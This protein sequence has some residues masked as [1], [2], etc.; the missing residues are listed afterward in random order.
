MTP[1]DVT[2]D[3]PG[4]GKA[5][6]RGSS[7]A[8]ESTEPVTEAVVVV[9]IKASDGAI[10][11]IE[12]VDTEGTRRDLSPGEAARLLDGRQK[13]TVEGLVLEAFEAGIAC[14]LDEKPDAG[15]ADEASGE[16]KE[17]VA[18]Y[19]ELLGDLIQRSPAKRLLKRDVLNIALLGTIISEAPGAPT[20][21][22]E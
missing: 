1:E 19:D 12:A 17:D 11:R 18:F 5:S 7:A 4:P 9:T 2:A 20:A 22:A 21:G 15:A 13:P 6:K 8:P 10:L 3:Q 16:S 14:V